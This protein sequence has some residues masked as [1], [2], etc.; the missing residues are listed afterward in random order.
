MILGDFNVNM[1]YFHSQSRQL[2]DFLFENN[3]YLLPHGE[4]YRGPTTNSFIDLIIT[5]ENEK[6]L[7]LD[8]K[9]F[10][11]NHYLTYATLYI[12]TPKPPESTI[13]FRNLKNINPEE[14]T[15]RLREFD[16]S[17]AFKSRDIDLIWD[18]IAKNITSVLD[19]VAPMKSY[20]ISKKSLPWLSPELKQESLQ[21]DRLYRRYRRKR[22]P[23]R[24]NAYKKLRDT[25]NEK[26]LLEKTK[27]FSN[28]LS[29]NNPPA[30]IWK[31]LE[32]L[33]LTGSSTSSKFSFFP[34]QHNSYFL[35]TQNSHP[36]THC[37]QPST[38]QDRPSFKF[39]NITLD[40]LEWTFKQFT[41]KSKGPDGFS[42]EVLKLCLPALSN[43]CFPYE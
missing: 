6:I 4:T 10:I 15:I 9:L 16:W 41:T 22:V 35:S 14:F 2:F 32:H 38:N 18:T 30:I 24:L 1:S 7:S 26:I 33:G 11:N 20:R 40:N 39:K 29:T 34:N 13:S 25:L 3:F 36:S 42:L 21:L 37:N 31:E 23:S 17:F 8:K 12:F 5:D 27:F 43:F 19:S 28:K